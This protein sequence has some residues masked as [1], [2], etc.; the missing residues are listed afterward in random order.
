MILGILVSISLILVGLLTFGQ[1][2]QKNMFTKRAW[3]SYF[4]T[5]KPG[6][7]YYS[8]EY[9]RPKNPFKPLPATTFIKIVEVRGKYVKYKYIRENYVDEVKNKYVEIFEPSY[10]TEHSMK[11]SDLLY[12]YPNRLKVSRK[13][14]LDLIEE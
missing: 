4:T 6:Q 12:E 9:K 11:I 14:K 3:F 13:D 2:V 5:P 10:I 1:I 7:I 8:H